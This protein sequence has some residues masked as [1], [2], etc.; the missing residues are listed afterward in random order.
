MNIE[1]LKQKRPE[2]RKTG[3]P[4][5]DFSSYILKKSKNNQIVKND[6]KVSIN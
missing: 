1:Q 2:N 5:K 4:E 3:K 6:F